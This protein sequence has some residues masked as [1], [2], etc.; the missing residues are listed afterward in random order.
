MKIDVKIKQNNMI[1]RFLWN[2]LTSTPELVFGRRI[3]SF[4]QISMKMVPK[5]SEKNSA[6]NKNETFWILDIK[7]F[8][9]M[10]DPPLLIVYSIC[11]AFLCDYPIYTFNQ[12]VWLPF[13]HVVDCQF[14]LQCFYTFKTLYKHWQENTQF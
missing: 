3:L 8:D 6:S 4:H 12:F 11:Q 1:L 2:C 14:G 9:P 5:Y 13:D 10:Y 7:V